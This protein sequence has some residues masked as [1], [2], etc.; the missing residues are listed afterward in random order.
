MFLQEIGSSAVA[1]SSEAGGEAGEQSLPLIVWRAP[2][3]A[4]GEDD[5]LVNCH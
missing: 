2:V 5:L 1:V 3:I 4:E